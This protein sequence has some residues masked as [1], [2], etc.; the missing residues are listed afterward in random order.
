MKIANTDYP[1]RD[2]YQLW[3][4]DLQLIGTDAPSG[5]KIMRACLE[6]MEMLIKK[7]VSYGDSALSPIRIF[8]QADNVE[9]IKIRIDDK[10]NRI[11]NNQGF[12]GDNDID[13]M[14]GYLILLKIALTKV[15]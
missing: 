14:I 6:I 12:A 15:E 7:N 5:S 2:S 4:N 8:A 1:N 10:I 9:Q 3:I 11:K 13:D